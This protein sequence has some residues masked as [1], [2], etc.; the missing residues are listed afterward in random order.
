MKIP[1]TFLGFCPASFFHRGVPSRL[2]FLE[3]QETLDALIAYLCMVLLSLVL[4]RLLFP[5]TLSDPVGSE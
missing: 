2:A 4:I 3:F 1:G 5:I